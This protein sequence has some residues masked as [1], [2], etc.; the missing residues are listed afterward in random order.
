MSLSTIVFVFVGFCWRRKTIVFLKVFGRARI[1]FIGHFSGRA[2]WERRQ[3]GRRRIFSVWILI[4]RFC[5]C[6]IK[7]IFNFQLCMAVITFTRL[8]MDGE[9][10]MFSSYLGVVEISLIFQFCLL[11]IFASHCNEWMESPA[12]RHCR[13]LLYN[14]SIR[15]YS[16]V[17]CP[18]DLAWGP[19]FMSHVLW[20][21]VLRAGQCGAEWSMV[22]LCGRNSVLSAC[23][24]PVG[25]RKTIDAIT[26]CC[27]LLSSEH[28]APARHLGPPRET[29]GPGSNEPHY[30]LTNCGGCGSQL[31]LITAHITDRGNTRGRSDFQMV[32]LPCLLVSA[33]SHFRS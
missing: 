13:L 2:R 4:L 8:Q 33:P 7:W 11:R 25:R 16:P 29:L 3:R 15:L 20:W 12:C 18:H 30:S 10:V 5:F 27:L 24:G 14:L 6:R 26:H 32:S 17:T 21:P 31:L 1:W 28:L 19:I 9:W 23:M 22:M